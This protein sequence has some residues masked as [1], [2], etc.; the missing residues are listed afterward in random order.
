MRRQYAELPGFGQKTAIDATVFKAWS[1]GSKL[2]HSDPEAGWS[3]KKG[4][5]G[6]KEPEDWFKEEY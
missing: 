1:N 2:P 3:V 4:T 5:N 6:R